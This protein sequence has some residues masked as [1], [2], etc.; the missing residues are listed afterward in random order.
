MVCL[1]DK[2]TTIG[3]WRRAV[4]AGCQGLGVGW[5][6]LLM[7]ARIDRWHAHTGLPKVTDVGDLKD[8]GMVC[9]HGCGVVWC[10]V[11]GEKVHDEWMLVPGLTSRLL[12]CGC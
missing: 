4:P 6:A 10:G 8:A 9:W 2:E 3:C 11:Y 1:R 7:G 12:G 5:V